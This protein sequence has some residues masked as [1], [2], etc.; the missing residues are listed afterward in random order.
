MRILHNNTTTNHNT[1]S[2]EEGAYRLRD[3]VETVTDKELEEFHSLTERLILQT[4]T[5]RHVHKISGACKCKSMLAEA[6]L[7]PGSFEAILTSA[8]LAV[9][10]AKSQSFA[11]TRPPGHHASRERADGF[12]FINNIAVATHHLLEQGS[13]VGII[14]IDGHHGNGT[15][16]IFKHEPRALFASIHQG[17]T[18]PHSGLVNDIGTGPSF[19]K[20]INIPLLEGSGDDVF[21]EAIAFVI[22]QLR[23]FDPD[24]VAVSAGFDGYAIDSLLKL[25]YSKQGYREAGR[26]IASIGKPVFAVL[27]GGYHSDIYSCVETFVAGV[28]GERINT[29][30]DLSISPT[31]C[32]EKLNENLQYLASRLRP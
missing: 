20:V 5:P 16:S 25:R 26:I 1:D 23:R 30:E 4:H 27:E 11:V 19:K 8:R 15:Q 24:Y 29:G 3:F 32:K 14:D 13:R 21:L 12:C 28:S 17:K 7:S 9:M 31:P 2:V 10:A 22:E 18:Y 6:Q